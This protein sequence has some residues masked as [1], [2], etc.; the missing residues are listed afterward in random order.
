V[1][2]SNR[3]NL[4]VIRGKVKGRPQIIGPNQMPW[5]STIGGRTSVKGISFSTT[6]PVVGVKRAL[7]P[8]GRFASAASSSRPG[9][10]N[11][12]GVKTKFHC[13]GSR[14]FVAQQYLRDAVG[15]CPIPRFSSSTQLFR[16]INDLTASKKYWVR[17]YHL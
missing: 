8:R 11:S 3:F 1:V 12:V 9:R 14:D 6:P 2:T 16:T 10:L 5:N 13:P 17:V 15:C 7:N 4:S